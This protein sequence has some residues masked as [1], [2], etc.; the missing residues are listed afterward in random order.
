MNVSTCDRIGSMG[1]A[2]LTLLLF[3]AIFFT[4]C[5]QLAGVGVIPITVKNTGLINGTVSY[6]NGSPVNS[7]TVYASPMDR[8]SIGKIPHATTD[9]T[10]HFAIPHLWLGKYAVG[11]EKL[12]ED[13]PDMT[14]QFYS[15]GK[16]ETVTLT[17]LHSIARVGI[18]LG[19]KAGIL[20]GTV[21]DAVTGAPLNP[22]VEF[23]RAKKPGNFLLGTG[24]V[25]AKYRVLVPS[26]TEV[27]MKVWYAGYKH[28]YYPGTMDKAEGR[29]VNLKPG[30]ETKLDIRLEPDLEAPPAGCGMPV[31]TVIQ[32]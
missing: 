2:E 23:R 11:A 14:S 1:R 12:D 6:E 21:S 7:A 15:D 17:S 5:A 26:N 22:C 3:V 13:Y 32:P 25:N 4:L 27:L 16:F 20:T 29:P 8:P 10:G 9:E 31:G 24:L 18:Q 30:E 28:W 19:P